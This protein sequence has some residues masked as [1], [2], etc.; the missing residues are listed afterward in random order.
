M[1][2]IYYLISDKGTRKFFESSGGT[3]AQKG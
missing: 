3:S 2:L 1:T